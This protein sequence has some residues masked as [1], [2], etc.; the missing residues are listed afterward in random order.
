[1]LKNDCWIQGRHLVVR[2]I[3]VA[4]C[5]CVGNHL[6]MYC[7]KVLRVVGCCE[8]KAREC[9]SQS[10]ELIVECVQLY[11]CLKNCRRSG[12]NAAYRMWLAS[13]VVVSMLYMYNVAL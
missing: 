11:F 9:T 12:D 8:F 2:S 5:P 4:G 10:I 13:L 3:F 1:M 6:W 7:I